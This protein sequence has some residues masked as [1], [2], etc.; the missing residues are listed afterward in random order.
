M[1]GL[2]QTSVDDK[3][4]QQLQIHYEPTP[5]GMEPHSEESNEWFGARPPVRTSV[6]QRTPP[7]IGSHSRVYVNT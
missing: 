1:P 7:S 2:I 3:C 5:F 6:Q 4:L